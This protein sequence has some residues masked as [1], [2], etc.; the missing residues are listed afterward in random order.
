MLLRLIL[1]LLQSKYIVKDIY[2]FYACV[3]LIDDYVSEP[4]ISSEH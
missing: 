4:H 2:Y 1:M 3:F